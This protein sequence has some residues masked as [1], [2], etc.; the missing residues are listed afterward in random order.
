MYRDLNDI[1]PPSRRRAMG[2]GMTPAGSPAPAAPSMDMRPAPSVTPPQAPEPPLQPVPPMSKPPRRRFRASGGFPFGTALIALVVIAV[3]AGV[4]YAFSGAKVTIAPVTNVANI[5]SDMSATQGQGDLPFQIITVDSTATANVPAES[6]V[7]AADPAS[8]KITITNRQTTAQALI[9][10]TRFQSAS[11][12]VFRIRDSVSIPAGASITATVYADEAGDKYNIGPTT[13]TVPGL[14]GSK[15][16]T[17]VTAKSDAPMTGGFSGTRPSV[18][19]ATKDTQYAGIQT[20]ITADLQ[21]ALATK[22]PA[23][24][25]LVPGA[26]FTTFTPGSDTAGASGTVTLSETG[27]FV[28]VVFPADALARA[29]AFK[30]VGTYGGQPVTVQDVSGL[31]AKPALPSIAP[32]AQTFDFNLAGTATIIW[33]VDPAKIAA[34]VAGKTRDSA[35]IALESFPEVGKATLV[36]R[37]F[38]STHFPGDPAKIKV[39]VT[40]PGGSK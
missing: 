40:Q 26:S 27:N 23:G 7:T 36:L 3:C 2:E 29:I 28:A 33:Q 22:M 14:Q 31:T 8:G 35:K 32:D 37:P 1:I 18:S 19:Q 13:F 21:K 39:T 38:W 20:K 11:G 17:Q 34:A 5:Q 6:T 30:S 16:Y 12:L 9:K 24:Y 10:N 4:L 15:S 25:V